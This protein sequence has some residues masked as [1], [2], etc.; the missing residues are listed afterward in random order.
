[1]SKNTKLSVNKSKEKRSNKVSLARKKKFVETSSLPIDQISNLQ[2]T[3]GNQAVQRLYKSGIFQAKLRIGKPGDKYEMEADRVADQVLRMPEMTTCLECKEKG[4]EPLQT[5][6]ISTQITPIV[7]RQVASEEKEEEPIQAKLDSFILQKQVEPEEEEEE[8][9]PKSIVEEVSPLIQKQDEEEKEEE[10]IQVKGDNSN[11]AV[12]TNGIESS[13]NSLKGGGQPLSESTRS[14]FEPRFGSNF[15]QVRIHNNSQAANVAKSINAKA[16]TTGKDIVFNSGQYS[17]ETSTGKRL[18]AHELT[19]VVQQGMISPYNIQ[20]DPKHSWVPDF[21]KY[22]SDYNHA[23]RYTSTYTRKTVLTITAMHTAYLKAQEEVER[24]MELKDPES[25][26]KTITFFVL[27]IAVRAIPGAGFIAAKLKRLKDVKGHGYFSAGLGE[28]IK[29]VGSYLVTRGIL[30]KPAPPKIP[31]KE[32]VLGLIEMAQDALSLEIT[33]IDTMFENWQKGWDK[34]SK[35]PSTCRPWMYNLYPRVKRTFPESK[36]FS[37][38]T[39]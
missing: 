15:N 10:S 7:S 8:I 26:W 31:Y 13:I 22:V 16:F 28:T 35:D 2:K 38:S 21:K 12:A 3:I 11:T 34:C 30:Y 32:G 4:E 18:L 33:D 29:V 27:A 37:A 23:W 5:K 19:H 1:M 14:Y 24:I 17:P 39:F 36:Y 20:L 25:I 6:P 9:Q